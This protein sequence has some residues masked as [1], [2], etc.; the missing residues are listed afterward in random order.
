MILDLRRRPE[1]D[2]VEE[3]RRALEA[4][5]PGE[6][7]EVRTVDEP[8]SLYSLCVETGRPHAVN[9]VHPLHWRLRLEPMEQGE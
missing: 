3:F 7:L 8:I 5:G 2:L 1:A 6:A 4:L 9:L